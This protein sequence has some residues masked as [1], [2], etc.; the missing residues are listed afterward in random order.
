M[1]QRFSGLIQFEGLLRYESPVQHTARI[2]SADTE[3]AGKKIIK[4]AKVVAVLAAANRD[5]DRFPDPDRLDL[6]RTDNRH[7]AFGQT[8]I[9]VSS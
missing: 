2:A 4:G 8:G 7:L 5:P 3:L 9:L 6:L 1:T